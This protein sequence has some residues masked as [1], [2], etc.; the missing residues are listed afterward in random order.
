MKNILG[1]IFSDIGV[2]VLVFV[3]LIIWMLA[4]CTSLNG[5]TGDV[6]FSYLS[7]RE[8]TDFKATKDGESFMVEIGR[9]GGAEGVI[10]AAIK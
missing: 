9:A 7:T 10:D 2:I 3:L 8:L 1:W 4:G 6:E 5:K